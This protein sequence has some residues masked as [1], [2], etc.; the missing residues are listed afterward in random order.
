MNYEIVDH[1]LKI[2]IKDKESI[3]DFSHPL[4]VRIKSCVEELVESLQENNFDWKKNNNQL[5]FNLVTESL[6]LVAKY[7]KMSIEDKKE[8]CFKLVEKLI[9]EQ[10]ENLG[11]DETSQLAVQLGVDTVLE[12]IIELA[13][14]TT[15]KK[16]KFAEKCFKCL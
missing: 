13:I 10:I 1:K 6:K 12:P 3:L 16:I 4:I 15:L 7:K 5:V 2:T 11:L 8:I 14:L 9:E